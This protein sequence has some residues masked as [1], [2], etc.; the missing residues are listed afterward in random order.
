[1]NTKPNSSDCPACLG[2]GQVIKARPVRLGTKLNPELCPKC[3]GTGKTLKP[4]PLL[5]G[6]LSR[7]RRTPRGVLPHRQQPQPE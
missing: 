3:A 4:V 1:M 6:R 7:A 5:P 2:T